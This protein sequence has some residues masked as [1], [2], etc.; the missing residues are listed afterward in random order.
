VVRDAEG[1]HKG[2][3]ATEPHGR[4]ACQE[5][6][7]RRGSRLSQM[8][9]M[10]S[11]GACGSGRA[12]PC[13]AVGAAPLPPDHLRAKPRVGPF[14]ITIAKVESWQR[15]SEGI[16][17]SVRKL[18][19]IQSVR[20]A[21]IDESDAIPTTLYYD[22]GRPTIGREAR[23]KCT[24]PELLIEDFKIELGRIDPDN[25]SR[26]SSSTVERSPRKTVW[27]LAKDFFDEVLN[28]FDTSLVLLSQKVAAD[29]I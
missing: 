13:Q 19:F 17:M 20:L 10:P 11:G 2:V 24:S 23:E 18:P 29:S 14:Q 25:P 12:G 28:K 26:R 6:G 9:P 22:Q 16:P 5:R 21:A 7:R 27:G 1:G 4:D 3:L 15:P 8:P